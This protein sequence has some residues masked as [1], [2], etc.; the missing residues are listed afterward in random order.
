MKILCK[1]TMKI[2]KNQYYAA[3]SFK[4]SIKYQIV[5]IKH[6]YKCS[7]KNNGIIL[8]KKIETRA[9]INNTRK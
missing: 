6:K 5:K 4:Q 8:I 3:T 1:S 7:I 2:H 9:E